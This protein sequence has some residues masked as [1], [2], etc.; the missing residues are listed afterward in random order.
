MIKSIYALS[1][2]VFFP[3]DGCEIFVASALEVSN[4]IFNQFRCV[5][6]IVGIDGLLQGDSIKLADG[7]YHVCAFIGLHCHFS[8]F[9]HSC[10][11][12]MCFRHSSSIR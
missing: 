8:V 3:N 11:L 10:M 7:F 4:S 2:V 6:L 9:T 5:G 12:S 1:L